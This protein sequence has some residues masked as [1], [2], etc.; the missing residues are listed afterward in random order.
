[1]EFL[2]H[3][4]RD[5]AR[6]AE[7]LHDVPADRRV[8]SCPD[9]TGDDLLWHLGKWQWFWATVVRDG[10]TG[11][12]VEKLIP[13]RPTGRPALEGFFAEANRALI[14][15]LTATTPETPAWSWSAEQTAGF[16]RRRQTHEALIHRIDAELVAGTRTPMDPQLSS[17]GVDE[18]LRIMY[19]GTPPWGRFDP[20]PGTALRIHAVDTGASWFVSLGRFSGTDPDDGQA[21][22]E[23]DLRAADVDTGE[24]VGATISGRAADLD[25]WLWHRPPTGPLERS[26]NEDLLTRFE[27]TIGSGINE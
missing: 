7:V 18:A 21:Y 13:E 22:D 20:E 11:D 4:A 6:F 24:E 2:D 5:S 15:I 8:P 14:D 10:L 17:D 27:T 25:C 9:W 16:T 23:P 12:E 3:L 1:L 19:G 26:G